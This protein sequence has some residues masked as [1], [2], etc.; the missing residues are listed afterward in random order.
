[1]RSMLH[2]LSETKADEPLRR[3][4]PVHRL[5]CA[6]AGLVLVAR[7]HP[8]ARH[9]SESLREQKAQKRYRAV[10]LGAMENESGK[11]DVPLSQQVCS[12]E[13]RLV[14][15]LKF[16]LPLGGADGSGEEVEEV[17]LSLVDLWPH[18]GRW[19][20]LRRHMSGIGHCIIG[21]DR[22]GCERGLAVATHA[23]VGMQLAAVEIEIPHQ[24]PHHSSTL[25][26]SANTAIPAEQRVELRRSEC[27]GGKL[28]VE[29]GMP[30]EMQRLIISGSY[31]S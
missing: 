8:A 25:D 28:H 11:I 18:T 23:G 22:H 20:Q 14:Q 31:E 30:A 16:R 12:S 5:D 4:A 19:H 13:W 24:T 2:Q 29:I 15:R 3:P 21:D 27:L 10:V 6:T 17:S 1:M 9:L 7:T 26:A